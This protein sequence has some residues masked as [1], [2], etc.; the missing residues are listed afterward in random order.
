MSDDGIATLR[1]LQARLEV[2]VNRAATF[3]ERARITAYWWDIENLLASELDD[4]TD[5]D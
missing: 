5:T 3:E 2:D 4:G 1:L